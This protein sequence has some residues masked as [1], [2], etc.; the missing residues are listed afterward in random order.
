E[1][2]RLYMPSDIQEDLRSTYCDTLLAQMEAD[3][4]YACATEGL[5]DL[6][7]QLH[8]R[9]YMV[10]LKIH[11][12]TGQKGNTRARGLQETIE[13]KV[14]D[15][16]ARYRTARKAFIA[17]KGND[18]PWKHKMRELKAGDVVGLGESAQREL[19]RREDEAI[20]MRAQAN[21][22]SSTNEAI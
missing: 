8:L 20:R 17:L 22:S 14:S 12:V 4:R 18:G 9:V 3:L 5:Q 1:T 2:I 6:R 15:A 7:R 13:V 10:K 19:L 16:A 21:R 11:N